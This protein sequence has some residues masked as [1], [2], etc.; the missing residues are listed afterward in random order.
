MRSTN[1][2]NK[3][4]P[5]WAS[6]SVMPQVLP[7]TCSSMDFPQCHSLLQTFTCS[8]IGS[9]MDCRHIPA[10]LWTSTVCRTTAYL[11]IVFIKGETRNAEE[12]LLWCLAELFLSHVL[13]P[14]SSCRLLCHSNTHKPQPQLLPLVKC[15]IPQSLPPLLMGSALAASHRNHSCSSPIIKALPQKP[16]T[17]CHLI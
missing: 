5:A 15:V 16:N 9:S 7:G 12:S 4:V 1:P 13:I 11:T 3:P 10:P 14:L 6:F 8:A 17:I 2:A